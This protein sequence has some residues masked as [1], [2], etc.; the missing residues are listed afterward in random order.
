MTKEN[1]SRNLFLVVLVSVLG[2]YLFSLFLAQNTSFLDKWN[3]WDAPWYI[4]IAQKGYVNEGESRFFIVYF[5]FYP[6][7]IKVFSFIFLDFVLSAL[8]VSNIFYI[9]AA[10]F[11]YRL[12]LLDYNKNAALMAVTFFSIFPTAYFLHAGY[13]ESLFVA[14]AIGS[15]YFARTEKWL[16]AS[17]LGMFA[18]ATRLVGII[19][20]PALLL[21]YFQQKNFKFSKIKKNV[22][23]IPLISAGLLVYLLINYSVFGDALRFSQVQKEHWA[24][25]SSVPLA[26]FG[27]ALNS[28]SWREGTDKITVGASQLVFAIMGLLFS[29]YS[30]K[31]LRLSYTFYIT[32]S[33]L[34]AISTSFWMSIPRFTLA[35]F[36]IFI[37][38]ASFRISDRLKYSLICLSAAFYI[39]FLSLFIQG[40]WA[41]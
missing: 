2:T 24:Q 17:V 16:A 15:F 14:L 19:L 34:V 32:A 18:S 5:P 4:D 8:I 39:F 29:L 31:K 28:M 25:E 26:G 22:L 27:G 13:T 41:F 36:P 7:L 37:C 21:E 23:F 11:L 12:V 3:R 10:Y 40:I 33:W 38:L 1:S 35:M 6:F 20:L 9:I 30:F